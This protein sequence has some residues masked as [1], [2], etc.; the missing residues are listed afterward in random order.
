MP[1][2]HWLD[3]GII[4]AGGNHEPY[5]FV[6]RR[7]AQRRDTYEQQQRNQSEAL[8]RWLREQGVEVFHTHLYEGFGM[9]AEKPGMEDTQRAA[10]I[11][12]CY[13][14]K[15]GEASELSFVIPSIHTYAIAVLGY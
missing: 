7:G 3:D 10:E 6:V 14:L 8:I 9:S 4:D 13:G 2:V 15:A 11:A 5:I 12:H 1:R